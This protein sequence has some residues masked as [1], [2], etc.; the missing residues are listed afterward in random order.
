VGTREE[1]QEHRETMEGDIVG[2]CNINHK[3]C[4]TTKDDGSASK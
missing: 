2:L 1:I 4:A 3:T